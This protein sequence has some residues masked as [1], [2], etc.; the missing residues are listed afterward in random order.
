MAANELITLQLI[1]LPLHHALASNPDMKSAIVAM[2]GSASDR[3]AVV[4]AN[5]RKFPA[6]MYSRSTRARGQS[7]PAPGRR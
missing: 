7:R 1:K 2:S 4:T 5:A 6:L 3:V